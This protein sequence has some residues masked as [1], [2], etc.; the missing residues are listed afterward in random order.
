MTRTLLDTNIVPD[1]MRNPQ[2][3]VPPHIARVG[4]GAIAPGIVTAA[5]LRTG[6]ARS[7]SPRIQARVAAILGQLPILPLEAPADA[8]YGTLRTALDAAGTPIGPNDLL[9]AAHALA[10]GAT[11]VTANLRE[12]QRVPGLALENWLAP[13]PATM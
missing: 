7:G 3:R 4:E 11:L 9:I 8:A 12:F 13:D 10:L 6:A 1:L 5:E 2:G